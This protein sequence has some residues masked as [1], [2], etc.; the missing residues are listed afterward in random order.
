MQHEPFFAAAPPADAFSGEE[1]L[2]SSP[3]KAHATP[4]AAAELSQQALGVAGGVQATP[5]AAATH[6]P[7]EAEASPERGAPA[8]TDA[9]AARRADAKGV[10]NLRRASQDPQQSSEVPDSSSNNNESSNH[11]NLEDLSSSEKEVVVSMGLLALLL[12]VAASFFIFLA[13]KRLHHQE[14][15]F[16]V[17]L[18]P[19]IVF[20]GGL[21]ITEEPFASA[22][23]EN[24]GSVLWLATAA[25]LCS[26]LIIGVHMLGAGMLLPG[27]SLTTRPAFAMGALISATDPVS[28]LSA[29]RDMK[30][31][32]LIHVLLFGESLLNDAVSLVL[33]KAVTDGELNTGLT[34]VAA[35]FLATFCASTALGVLT[36]AAVA[37]M[38]KHIGLNREEN[39]AME[40][41]LLLLFP[42]IAYL[43]ADGCGGS[44]IVSICFCG[45]S[46]GKYAFPNLSVS[47]QVAARGPRHA[48]Q[49]TLMCPLS[50]PPAIS[51]YL[52]CFF[53]N[54]FRGRKVLSAKEQHAIALCG[55]RGTV[56][57]ALAERAQ[58]DFGGF[59]GQAILT[60]TLV[61]ALVSVLFLTP[62]LL[63]A[64]RP[65]G[66][67]VREAS[68]EMASST[69]RHHRG[70]S[71]N[72]DGISEELRRTPLRLLPPFSP[73][74]YCQLRPYRLSWCICRYL[75]PFFIN[76]QRASCNPEQSAM[77]LQQ[78]ATG[79][80]QQQRQHRKRGR[81][82]YA[83][84]PPT[85]E[86]LENDSAV[87]TNLRSDRELSAQQDQQRQLP[88]G[89]LPRGDPCCL[90]EF[91]MAF[92]PS[93]DVSP[94]GFL[95][96]VQKPA[97]AG[98][99]PA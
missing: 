56:A 83:N 68:D 93:E 58:H 90:E 35:S 75:T 15:V 89:S 39:L 42:W 74:Q 65:L 4:L 21:E 25:T 38:Y 72:P 3:A 10:A 79:T 18:L 34:A 45:I 48:V 97:S 46:M 37:L 55:L 26:T 99:S 94:S 52:T 67:F 87:S 41:A 19:P 51:V 7:A 64:L 92:S 31:T 5:E 53:L 36:G 22:F 12:I 20:Q 29:F 16:F 2:L 70:E 40:V 8:E 11:D 86:S 95:Q 1:L 54:L 47:A 73:P 78:Y 14:E 60:L 63:F 77:E 49:R 27:V 81:S 23:A 66:I 84:I 17:L 32:L 30:A 71:N 91:D 88:A 24:F 62:A 13:A 9:R 50:L 44:G 33:Y 96:V 82:V 69:C 57:F 80:K 85:L 28:L 76:S 43:I 98:A 61:V 59:E 6:A